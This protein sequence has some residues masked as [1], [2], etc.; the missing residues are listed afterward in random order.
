MIVL[1][2]NS[3]SSSVKF[4]VYDTTTQ[5]E[6]ARGSA[7]G[8][9]D[10]A[11]GEARL[12]VPMT[13]EGPHR[14]IGYRGAVRWMIGALERAGVPRPEAIGHRVVHGGERLTRPTRIDATVEAEIAACGRLA[15]LHNA[16]NLLGIRA[17]RA[18]FPDLDQVAVFDTGFHASLPPVAARY[19]IPEGLYRAHGARR[20]GFHGISHQWVTETVAR[21]LGRSEFRL[22]SCHL[23]AGASVAAVRDGRSVDTSMGMTPTEGLVM[24]TRPGDL[25]PA[26]VPFVMRVER[27]ST[28]AAERWLNEAC[29]LLALAGT[30]DMRA[31]E[32]AA[33][34]GDP[35]ARFAIELF[36]YRVRKYV[37]A[38]A[39]VLGGLD[40]LAFTGGIGEN[41]P[42]VRAEI[43]RPLDWLGIRLDPARNE[44]VATA[45][46][47]IGSDI[48][49]VRVFV[50][51]AREEWVIA[52][53]TARVLQA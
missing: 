44:A 20:Y 33:A 7:V 21:R 42:A 4:A 8:I 52:R 31:I 11:G 30:T 50:V 26:L 12:A 53:E 10:R 3:G 48:S 28:R 22:I 40:A 5:T 36:C 14:V 29:G 15:P 34:A 13:G 2:V 18:G 9:R 19:A 46:R 39:A 23:G 32:A 45:D 49:D 51:P 27:L 1:V 17:C 25:D 41:S 37:G 38:Y 35:R 43:C 16:A 6:L 47:E 24:A